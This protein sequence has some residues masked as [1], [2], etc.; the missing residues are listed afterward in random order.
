MG[1]SIRT[2][3]VVFFLWLASQSWASE[4][5]GYGQITELYVNATGTIVRVQFSAGIKNPDGCDKSSY[6]MR[7][8]ADGDNGSRFLSMLLA[9]KMSNATVQFWINGCTSGSYWGGTQP[10]LNDIYLK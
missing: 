7:E 6:Y 9:A 3:T 4:S 1:K 5:S 8:L 2:M 10:Q